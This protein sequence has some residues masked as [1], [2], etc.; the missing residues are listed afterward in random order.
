MRAKTA[1]WLAATTHQ[2]VMAL[3]IPKMPTADHAVID[4]SAATTAITPMIRQ[5]MPDS[6]ALDP[7]SGKSNLKEI[8][9]L[10]PVWIAYWIARVKSTAP[11]KSQPITPTENAGCSSRPAS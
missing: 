10:R 2:E 3:Q 4:K 9:P 7:V 1:G 5:S 6:E 8:L 11:L